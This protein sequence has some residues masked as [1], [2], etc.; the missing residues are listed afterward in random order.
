MTPTLILA[1]GSPRRRALLATLGLEPAKIVAAA[2]DE[3]PRRGELPRDYAR[4]LA[5][6]KL[7]MVAA[8]E[9]VGC[10]LAAD[11]VVACGRRILPKAATPEE[12]T[13]CL[14]LLSGRRHRV[15][16]ALAFRDG[17][18]R[19][20]EKLSESR[21]LF[22]KLSRQQIA[23][24]VA[25]GEGLDKAGGYALQGRAAAFV[26]QISGSWSGIV[27]LPLFETAQLLRAAGF[28]V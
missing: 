16:T 26:R 28:K 20:H 5:R 25:N 27:G 1:S 19:I 6:A 22:Q 3:T 17:A 4:R 2:L 10:V 9:P 13:T 18:G 23:A 8:R 11:T 15:L 14:T 24:Y 12:V 21:V 7:E